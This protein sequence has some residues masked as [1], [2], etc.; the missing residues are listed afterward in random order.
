MILTYLFLSQVIVSMSAG[1]HNNG[2]A[3]VGMW[4]KLDVWGVY[5]CEVYS[6]LAAAYS[7]VVDMMCHRV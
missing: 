2:R 5:L 4:G 7:I 6:V 1:H 3:T